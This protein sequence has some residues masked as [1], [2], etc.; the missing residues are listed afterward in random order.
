M[1]DQM[2]YLPPPKKLLHYV[3]FFC[4]VCWGISAT[5]VASH[6]GHMAPWFEW[7]RQL[8]LLSFFGLLTFGFFYIEYVAVECLAGVE[9]NEK[10]GHLQV[11]GSAALLLVAYVVDIA[12]LISNDAQFLGLNGLGDTLLVFI[13]ILG[14]GAFLANIVMTYAL[15]K[16]SLASAHPVIPISRPAVPPRTPGFPVQKIAERFDWSSSPTGIFGSAAAFFILAGIFLI[17]KSPPRMPL[18]KDGAITYVSPGYLWL[19]LA[20]PFAVFAVIYWLVEIFTGRTFD[21]L[22][23]RMHFVCTILA[24]L[25]AIRIYS[26]WSTTTSNVNSQL[27]G[28]AD[29]FGVFAFLALAAG[30]LVWNI[31]S[32]AAPPSRPVL[33]SAP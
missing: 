28:V 13:A 1:F 17:V 10:L 24:V 4:L 33:R 27:P 25:D 7:T 19:P 11:A 21:R 32:S 23:T 15:A 20:V 6:V 14:E 31:R 26:S 9:L 12:A 8:A 29:F 16:G 2:P 22:A 18:M 3:C 30:A 5:I